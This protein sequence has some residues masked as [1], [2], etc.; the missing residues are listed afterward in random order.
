MTTAIILAG[1]LGTRLRSVVPDLPK[2]MAP[3]NGRPFLEHQ[4]D[5]WIGQGVNRFVISVGHMKELIIRHFGSSYRD[6]TVAYAIEDEPLGTGGALLLAAQGLSETFL[7]L[8][9]DTFFAVKLDELLRFHAERK[10]EW[11][12]SLF[13]AD[14]VGR[15]MGMDVSADG[16]IVSHQSGPG[17]ECCLA[18]GGVYLL[19]PSVL[20]RL[21]FVTGCK[22][23]LEDDLLSAFVTQGGKL[24]GL[25]CSGRFIDIGVPR[26]FFRAAEILPS[27][28]IHHAE[29]KKYPEE[30]S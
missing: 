16:E 2:P 8:N 18:N 20:A 11:T 22:L 13:K 21:K 27:D 5:Y 12:F 29:H 17:E 28:E 10:S 15:Y 24:Y 14:E 25:A 3:I 23:S 1:G 30:K 7:V 26:D 4:M 9:G 19:N 6:T